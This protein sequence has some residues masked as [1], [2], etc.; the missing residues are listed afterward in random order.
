MKQNLPLIT[1]V[2]I[3]MFLLLIILN[4]TINLKSIGIKTAEQKAIDISL[5]VK[6][7]LTSQMVT[8]TIEKREIFLEQI[9]DIKNIEKIW[10]T[11]SENI[12]KQ[13]GNGLASENKKDRIDEKVLKEGKENILLND[14]WVGKN[15]LRYTTPYKAE[16]NGTINCMNCHIASEG[17]VLGTI[18][19][20]INIDDIKNTGVST[21][22]NISILSLIVARLFF[23]FFYFT[24]SPFINFFK[25]IKNVMKFAENGDYS[26]RVEPTNNE[27]IKDVSIWINNL[28]NKIETSLKN[29]EQNMRVFMKYNDSDSNDIL[30]NVQNKSEE[31]SNIYNFKKIIEKNMTVYDIYEKIS[32]VLI[33][34]FKITDFSILEIDT[35]KKFTKTI[36]YIKD[37]ESIDTNSIEL[38]KYICKDEKNDL[39]TEIESTNY[40]SNCNKICEKRKKQFYICSPFN[41]NKH[42]TLLLNF[43]ID[44]KEEFERIKKL[45]FKIENFIEISKTEIINKKLLDELKLSTTTDGLTSLFNRKF[46]DDKIKI[47]E[48]EVTRVDISYGILMVDIDFF[49]EVN[50]KYGHDIGDKA[51]ITMANTLI[52]NT[53][54]TDCVIRYGGEEF[55]VILW[56]CQKDNVK[57]VAEKIR[58]SFNKKIIQR[59]NENFSKTTS[60]GCSYFSKDT[61]PFKDMIKRADIALYQAKNSGRNKSVFQEEFFEFEI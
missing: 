57:L 36:I 40:L 45:K 11:R 6:H 50:D 5:L 55:L 51:I 54:D 24:F 7:S 35:E 60:I 1:V 61:L 39:N 19:I 56:N 2:T 49:K 9:K 15:T 53:R 34:Y 52:E 12:N 42:L 23:L 33:N 22:I 43:Q 3:F 37:S 47:I 32:D 29:I 27:N 13:F 58:E 16:S 31:L 20:I 8:N 17:E 26:K 18:S 48:K 21:V 41:L 30:I 59:P 25:D 28:L 14:N 38:Q 44:T 46:L 4:V 10:I